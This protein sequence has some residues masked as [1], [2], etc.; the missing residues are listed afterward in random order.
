M[1]RGGGL[2]G[3]S[4]SGLLIG[5]LVPGL[6]LSAVF[7]AFIVTIGWLKPELAPADE[8]TKLPEG[9]VP[10]IPIVAT[11]SFALGIVAS[12]FGEWWQGLGL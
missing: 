7:I 9:V 12:I 1:A 8:G 4:I 5:G 2:S 6:I 10:P 3:I 11:V